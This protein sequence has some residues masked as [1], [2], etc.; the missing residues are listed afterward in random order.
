MNSCYWNHTTDDAKTYGCLDGKSRVCARCCVENCAAETPAW[1]ARCA[2][3]GHPTWPAVKSGQGTPAKLVCL[4]SYWNRELFR[5][6]SV[7]PFFE[8]LSTLIRPRLQLAHRFVESER[9]L[10]YYARYPDGLLWQLSESWNAPIYY[11]AFHGAC[12]SV[13]SILD[14]IG[15]EILMETFRDY[16][17]C[18]YNNLIYF[19]ACSVLHGSAGKQFAH[20]F[21]RAT[22]SRAVIGYT[23]EV[24]W[25]HSLITDMLFLQRFYSHDSPWKNLSRI[26]DSVLKDYRPAKALGYT[27]VEP[28]DIK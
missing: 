28:K 1:F 13:K 7:K 19:A 9:G 11:L 24:D 26:F 20:E 5:T 14:S 23:T 16:G 15:S 17:R 3:A 22:G 10:S 25:M 4:E 21:L 8:A 2:E 27:L 6:T 12:G 18:G